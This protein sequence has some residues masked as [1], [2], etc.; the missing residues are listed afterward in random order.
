[1]N[2]LAKSRLSI[3]VTALF[4]VLI[5]LHPHSTNTMEIFQLTYARENVTQSDH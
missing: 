1:M 5:P 3:N 4:F 2:F